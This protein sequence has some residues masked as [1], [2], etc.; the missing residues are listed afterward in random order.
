MA[1][2]ELSMKLLINKESQ[3]VCFTEAGTD[4]VEFLAGLLSLPL[5]TM[6]ALLAKEHN[7]LGSIGSLLGSVEK[8]GTNYSSKP[9][10]LSPAVSP[11]ALSRLQQLLGAQQKQV[12]ITNGDSTSGC[13]YGCQGKSGVSNSS[14]PYGTTSNYASCP[15]V[16]RIYG[17]ACQGC[18]SPMI[19]VMAL[20]QTGGNDRTSAKTNTMY[21]IGDD[22]SVTPASGGVLSG[23][24]MLSRCHVKDL[25][26]LQEKTVKIGKEEVTPII[27]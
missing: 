13:L 27:Q 19:K 20:V 15:Y 7:M 5:C 11:A 12:S 21:T 3:K 9:R 18:G 10:H 4:V 16:S 25:S 8:M 14:N 2:D 26:V 24:S 23:I 17:A 22:L 6:A 1:T